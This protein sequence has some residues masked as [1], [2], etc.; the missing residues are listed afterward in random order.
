MFWRIV[1]GL[2]AFLLVAGVVYGAVSQ[3]YVGGML[4]LLC[5]AGFTFI[6]L[7][8]RHSVR[9]ADA[10]AESETAYEEPHIGPTIW[11][12]VLAVGGFGVVLGIA[13]SPWVAVVG[14]ALFVVAGVGW[15]LD[16]GRQWS[17]DRH[18]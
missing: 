4:F 13:V 1:L 15:F 17:H 5:A 3:E 12:F 8:V 11:P 9:E 18:H 16:V 2:A 10:A 7:F 6:G 14:A